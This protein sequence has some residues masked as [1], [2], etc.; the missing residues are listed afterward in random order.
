VRG[1]EDEWLAVLRP[2]ERVAHAHCHLVRRHFFESVKLERHHR[3]VD[4]VVTE[5]R[6]PLVVHWLHHLSVVHCLLLH[7][8]TT[9]DGVTD[10]GYTG[11]TWH[12]FDKRNLTL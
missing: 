7:L 12:Q 6:L 2:A 1:C 4:V 9:T 10:V 11:N 5:E 8:T 3:S